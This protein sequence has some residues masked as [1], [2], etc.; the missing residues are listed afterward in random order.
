MSPELAT[1]CLKINIE[2]ALAESPLELSLKSLI[3]SKILKQQLQIFCEPLAY[4][5]CS[6]KRA[7]EAPI[8]L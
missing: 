3:F 5:F 4:I 8:L 1:Y 2:K 7:P 6:V